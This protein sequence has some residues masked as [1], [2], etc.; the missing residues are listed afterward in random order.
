[1]IENNKN[2]TPTLEQE[3]LNVLSGIEKVNKMIPHTDNTSFSSM[4]IQFIYQKHRYVEELQTLL[5]D[6]KLQIAMS[7]EE[8][9][10]IKGVKQKL[11]ERR[12]VKIGKD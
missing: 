10:A 12:K 6:H 5:K 1:M 9:E 8:E 3:I 2:N 7:S 11:E 4:D